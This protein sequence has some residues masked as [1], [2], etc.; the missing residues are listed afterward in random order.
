[1][2]IVAGDWRGRRI[3]APKGE[4]TRPTSDRVREALFSSLTVLLGPGL[5]GRSVLDPFAGSGALGLEALSRGA[6]H[7][8]FIEHER[9]AREALE[10]NAEA[11]KAAARARIIAGDAFAVASH[12]PVPGGPFGLILLDPPYRI[13]AARTRQL[14]EDLAEAGAL[15]DDAVVTW[16]HAAGAGVSWPDGLEPRASKRYGSTAVDIAVRREGMDVLA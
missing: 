10:D 6:A 1:M 12:G 9:R 15:T 14:L 13:D 16:E 11:L 5:G 8:T 4:G 3:A 2:R 7:A